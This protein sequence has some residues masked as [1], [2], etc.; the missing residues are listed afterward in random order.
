M[1]PYDDCPIC[2][3]PI[4][5]DDAVA[6][7]G[8]IRMHDWCARNEERPRS[9]PSVRMTRPSNRARVPAS[10]AR[11]LKAPWAAIS[12]WYNGRRIVPTPL[13]QHFGD[14]T[15]IDSPHTE[16]HWTAKAARAIVG[17]C[18]KHPQ[19]VVGTALTIVG[20]YLAWLALD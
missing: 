7:Q 15:F 14:V 5:P 18:R 11:L 10:A 13:V 4:R 17:Y 16:Y 1:N 2:M 20:L 19:F 3:A 12:R 6:Y 9:S 8:D